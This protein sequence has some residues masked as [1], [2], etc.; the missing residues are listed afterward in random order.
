MLSTL[1]IDHVSRLRT[2]PSEGDAI[3]SIARKSG[4]RFSGQADAESQLYS[5]RPNRIF[6]LML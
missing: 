6:G 3:E 1:G 2:F 5:I 4:S